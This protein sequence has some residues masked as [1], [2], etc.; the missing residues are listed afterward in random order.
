[1]CR[2]LA[3]DGAEVIALLRPGSAPLNG[4]ASLEGDLLH[5]Q[6]LTA[7]LDHVRPDI[8]FHLAGFTSAA[9]GVEA[10]L[11]SFH[12]N[13]ASVVNLLTAAT[14]VGCQR[15]VLAGSLEEPQGELAIPS[16]PYAASKGAALSYARMFWR[17]YRTPVTVARIF[18]VYGPGQRDMNKLIPYTILSLLRG[19]ELHFSGGARLVDW[20]FVDDVARGLVAL[21]GTADAE[22][23][24]VDLGTGVLTSVRQIV[25]HLIEV[26]GVPARPQF[27]ALPD[28][29]DEQVRRADVVRTEALLG[30]RPV[31][32]LDEGLRRTV[33]FYRHQGKAG[34]S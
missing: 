25:E 33:E 5:P 20:V 18:M 7:S 6:R 28:R 19:D 12:A 14:H 34:L 17:L 13:V 24:S 22:G 4:I 27:G 8:I 16:S 10:V 9:R 3:A 26:V 23:Q 11:P 2:A 32:S 29:P 15:V 21:S 1:M 31:V 30:W